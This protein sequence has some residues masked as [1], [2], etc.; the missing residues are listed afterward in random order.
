[1]AEAGDSLTTPS[2][3]QSSSQGS[4]Q[5]PVAVSP[6][7]T[8]PDE[9]AFRAPED[10]TT[11]EHQQPP[12]PIDPAEEILVES[13]TNTGSLRELDQISSA[14]RSDSFNSLQQTSSPSRSDTTTATSNL[15]SR[16]TI[17]QTASGHK[18]ESSYECTEVTSQDAAQRAWRSVWLLPQVLVSFGVLFTAM[19]I[20]TVLLYVQ[21]EKND[22]LATQKQAYHYLWKYG[23]TAFLLIVNVLWRQVD[24]ANKIL[25]PWKELQNGPA[26]SDKTVLLDYISPPLP[27]TCWNAAKNRHFAVVLSTVGYVLITVSSTGLLILEPT[28][29]I[30]GN[31]TLHAK[32]EFRVYD[33]FFPIFVDQSAAQAYYAT[34]SMGMRRPSGTFDDI[35]I[36]EIQIPDPST[37]Y[38]GF[39]TT[40]EGVKM[41]YNCEILPVQNQVKKSIV[42]SFAYFKID[43]DKPDCKIQNFGIA[44][45]TEGDFPDASGKA[46]RAR[47]ESHPCNYDFDDPDQGLA[48]QYE[49]G[50]VDSRGIMTVTELFLPSQHNL[51][52]ALR[53]AR[54]QRATA[55]VCQPSYSLGMFDVQAKKPETGDLESHVTPVP[56][57]DR[58]RLAELSDTTF[59][60]AVI[61]TMASWTDGIN[62]I[63]NETEA[64]PLFFQL[65]S[66]RMGNFSL[67]NFLDSR[68]LVEVGTDVFKGLAVQLFY[69]NFLQPVD[70]NITGQIMY[71]RERLKVTALSTGFMC[72]FLV[73]LALIATLL[74]FVRPKPVLPHQPGSIASTATILASSPDFLDSLTTMDVSGLGPGQLEGL[75]YQGTIATDPDEEVTIQ[76]LLQEWQVIQRDRKDRPHWRPITSNPIFIAVAAGTPLLLVAAFEVIQHFSDKNQGFV[77]LASST[78]Q[79]FIPYIP[80]A[81]AL[82]L[83]LLY[84]SFELSVMIFA[85]FDALKRGKSPARRSVNLTYVGRLLP[86]AAA[87]A[88]KSRH[89]AVA[90][91]I[92]GS[93]ISTFLPI[94][95]SGLYSPSDVSQTEPAILHQSDVFRYSAESLGLSDF[96]ASTISNLVTY[97]DLEYPKWTYKNLV[98][99]NLTQQDESTSSRRNASLGAT[100]RAVRPKLNCT[101]V[102]MSAQEISFE[103]SDS[104]SGPDLESFE[105][106]SINIQSTAS[107][108][109]WCDSPPSRDRSQVVWNESFTVPTGALPAYFGGKT[110]MKWLDD[111]EI[112]GHVE[113]GWPNMTHQF[114]CP[115]FSVLLGTLRRSEQGRNSSQ[116]QPSFEPDFGTLLCYQNFEEVETNVTWQMPSLQFDTERPPQPIDSTA[117]NVKAPHGSEKFE[118]NLNAWSVELVDVSRGASGSDPALDDN[119]Y[120]KFIR[121]AVY[122]KQGR[123]IEE[124]AGRKNAEKL[125]EMA[126]TLYGVYMAQSISRNSRVAA[127]PEESRASSFNG[128][129][130]LPRVSRLRQNRSPKIALQVMLATMSACA[131][132]TRLLMP[133]REVLP[134]NPCSIAGMASLLAGSRLVARDFIPRGAQ[135]RDKDE[136]FG[137]SGWTYSLRWWDGNGDEGTGRPKRYGIDVD[138]E[139]DTP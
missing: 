128:T 57:E 80:T 38:V 87:S 69:S 23:P 124:L 115:T 18:K 101:M 78:S 71:S 139:H 98:F 16:T 67:E 113:D 29:L 70:R 131:V 110:L 64:M 9:P 112:L 88:I 19:M 120:D 104:G 65:M 90:T 74:I 132:L 138:T 17:E 48:D 85:P 109:D 72:G 52:S 86:Q 105:E 130:T 76:P 53:N 2:R 62:Y 106:V 58:K 28:Q 92:L 36:P 129:V 108:R 121:A 35:I 14:Q 43:I 102:P 8:V 30:E 39:T 1:M 11:A 24:F 77:K 12:A 6:V 82:G 97:A 55:A 7:S 134:H 41:E 94:V 118:Y 99:S 107:Y 126:S 22:G 3:T 127:S 45:I 73:C 122:G 49:N 59:G 83:S 111:E 50:T 116:S 56:G 32:T 123:P 66:T 79:Q 61:A 44:Q 93:L 25:M 10:V 34:Q 135:W 20:T 26:P 47:F 60:A 103:V 91:A 100:V 27:I 4:V 37:D 42:D 5:L 84:A 40:V 21:S 89:Y 81:A 33:G 63:D 15:G 95:I 133:M 68:R 13:P 114:G 119:R 75:Y 137:G 136:V 51:T 54:I 96:E 46:Y 117:K 31:Y 125:G